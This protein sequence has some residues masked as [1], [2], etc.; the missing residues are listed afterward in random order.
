[1]SVATITCMGR[2]REGGGDE[3]EERRG[4]GRRRREERKERGSVGEVGSLYLC[5]AI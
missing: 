3:G 1:M 4:E 2:R 5:A